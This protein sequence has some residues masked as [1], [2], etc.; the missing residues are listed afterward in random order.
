MHYGPNM[1]PRYSQDEFL[2]L[3]ER[4]ENAGGEHLKELCEPQTVAK[5]TGPH[6]KPMTFDCCG[7]EALFTV[8]Y[9]AEPHG[10]A[11][12][13]QVKDIKVCAVEDAIGA[14][15]RFG[16]DALAAILPADDKKDE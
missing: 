11:A 1:N 9:E 7:D 4:V 14:W 12:L 16:G 8:P 15:P 5:W 13:A 6:Q 10:E 3:I 2:D